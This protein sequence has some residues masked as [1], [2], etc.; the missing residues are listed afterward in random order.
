MIVALTDNILAEMQRRD[1]K[2]RSRLAVRAERLG[3]LLLLVLVLLLGS[4]SISLLFFVLFTE[5]GESGQRIGFFSLLSDLLPWL[6]VATFVAL[7]ALGFL[8]Y[9]KTRYGYRISPW[10]LL[11]LLCMAASVGGAIMYYTQGIFH[12]HRYFMGHCQSYRSALLQYR[13]SVWNDAARGR[14][15]GVVDSLD[16]GEF[17]LRDFKGKRWRVDDMDAQW[18]HQNERRTGDTVRVLG[19]LVGGGHFDA[20]VVLPWR[21]KGPGGAGLGQGRR[22]GFGN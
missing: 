11:V 5:V 18:R 10:R 1:I 21:S 14:L 3:V 13:A 12:V 8:L 16:F 4:L 17:I 15:G 22:H 6:G 7:V 19:R 9:R 2:P 20:D